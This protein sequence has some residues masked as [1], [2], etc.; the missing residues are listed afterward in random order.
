MRRQ[1]RVAH[2]VA[3]L[4]D[5]HLK[6][7]HNDELAGALPEYLADVVDDD[8]VEQS[9]QLLRRIGEATVS[10]DAPLRLRAVMILSLSIDRIV[11]VENDALLCT[12]GEILNGWLRQEDEFIAGYEVLCRQLQVVCGIMLQTG[13]LAEAG[14]VLETL[15]DMCNG[16]LQKE[17]SMRGV[18]ARTLDKIAGHELL[19]LLFQRFTSL[20]GEKQQVL[21]HILTLLGRRAVVYALELIEKT[22]ERKGR[23][24]LLRFLTSAGRTTLQVFEKQMAHEGRWDICCDMLHIL[25]AM[26]DDGVYPLVARTLQHPDSRVQR[27]AVDSIIRLGGDS[28]IIRLAEAL[29]QVN[30][31]LKNV[32]VKKL[33]KGD[34]PIIR[35]ALLTLLDDKVSHREFSDDM[36]LSSV[37]VALRPYPD[38]RVLIQ[39]REFREYLQK[40]DGSNKLMHLL[41]DTLLILE[42][43]MRH[44]RHRKIES[45][46]VGFDDDPEAV[47]QAKRKT[48]EVEKEVIK[49]LEKGMGDLAA[50]K[51]YQRCLEA[52]R[53]KDFVTAERLRDRILGTDSSAV[54]LVIEADEVIE[55]EKNS[56]IPASF[57]ETWKSLQHRIGGSGFEA[58]YSVLVPEQFGDDEIIAR[59]G[60]HDDR[61][62][63][64][65]SGSVSLECTTG[66]ARTFLKRLQPGMV[67]GGEQFFAI[68]VWTITARAGKQVEL[69]SLR[70]QDLQELEQQFSGITASLQAF[71]AG[72]NSTAKLLKMSGE[73]RRGSARYP[74]AATIRMA[75]V[76][77]Y[78]DSSHRQFVCRLQDI[79]QGGF[80]Y[81]VG[82]ADREHVRLLFGRQVRFDLK[83]ENDTIFTIE[84]IVV[85]IE[86]VRDDS[87]IYRAHARIL[88]PLSLNDVRQIVGMIT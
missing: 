1:K 80:C 41:D 6:L 83:F 52:A 48:Q 15:R 10:A 25:T 49:L 46:Q 12:L 63:F 31:G 73:D 77:A 42:S 59:E 13:H 30:D 24:Q 27:E 3:E 84:G 70:R 34:S 82:I 85:G 55:W 36:L 71:C 20:T 23:E 61:L 21:E 78:G 53:E 56:R 43:E 11:A 68:T 8:A 72:S 58:L 60:E 64:I 57:S 88:E 39:L 28:L 45:A 26:N 38:T 44:R 35:D 29:F 86:Q 65:S 79:S 22:G 16:R 9:L 2:C 40:G 74:V 67:I 75:L 62:Y 50:Q 37:V 14:N 17:A 33:A 47:R 81:D 66:S 32:I 5:G 69:Y 18:A 76:D 51:L 7:L 54:D 4:Q 87:K 19:V